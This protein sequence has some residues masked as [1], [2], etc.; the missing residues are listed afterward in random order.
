MASIHVE[1]FVAFL[2]EVGE[3]ILGQAKRIAVA[4]EEAKRLEAAVL[5]MRTALSGSLKPT[6][7]SRE[8]SAAK[9]QAASRKV[10]PKLT[11]LDVIFTMVSRGKP[12]SA[13][14]AQTQARKL[15]VDAN[16]MELEE[17][18]HKLA[19]KGQ[20]TEIKEGKKVTRWMSVADHLRMLEERSAKAK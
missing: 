5:E 18:C 4:A 16:W 2:P 3:P 15:G 9:E 6:W 8:I 7:S 19:K 17:R 12:F 1:D 20:M 10:P 13:A 14:Q 11:I